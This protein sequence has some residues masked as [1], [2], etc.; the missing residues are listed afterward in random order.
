[1]SN[2]VVVMVFLL[3]H[4]DGEE[5]AARDLVLAALRQS[6]ILDHVPEAWL[7][8]NERFRVSGVV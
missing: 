5:R 1:M 8:D 7:E 2:M 6:Q 3:C 4:V